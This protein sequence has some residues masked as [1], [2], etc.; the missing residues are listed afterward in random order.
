M[1]II[2]E[3]TTNEWAIL[4]E[5]WTLIRKQEIWLRK[6]VIIIYIILYIFI[7]SLSRVRFYRR[8]KYLK[9]KIYYRVYRQFST[10]LQVPPKD[11]ARCWI[12]PKREATIRDRPA[13]IR[14]AV[15]LTSTTKMTWMRTMTTFPTA[16]KTTS[17]I[18]VNDN[19]IYD[20]LI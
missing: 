2:T 5:R 9:K 20:Y 7:L 8:H 17:R 13:I 11:T 3:P 4:T 18:M 6:T 1:N 16:R 15:I 10:R 14:L 12:C 19:A